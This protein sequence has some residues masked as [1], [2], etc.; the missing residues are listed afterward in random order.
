MREQPLKIVGIC[1]SLRR[2]SFNRAL[3]RAA[4]AL[5]PA[6][7]QI[8]TVEIAHI[9]PFNEDLQING[10]PDPIRELKDLVRSSDALLIASPEYNYNIP[11]V[12]KNTL[13]WLSRPVM[14]SPLVGKP[15]AIMGAASGR[16]GTIRAQ[17]ALRQVFL[18]TDTPVLR[19]PEVYVVFA[20]DKFD[21]QGELTDERTIA[22]V[23]ELIDQ[24]AAAARSRRQEG[25]PPG[26]D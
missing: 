24:L 23:R 4:V 18:F 7:V 13:D 14:D 5:A 11:G 9:P 16:S 26:I 19:K 10:D 2:K 22:E 21:D 25:V 20:R 6:G 1:G 12:L 3:L 17:L 15:T 8:E